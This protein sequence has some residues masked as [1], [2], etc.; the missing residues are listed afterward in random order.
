MTLTCAHADRLPLA[1]PPAQRVG[2]VEG[3]GG[4]E[5]HV[6][7]AVDVRERLQLVPAQGMRRGSR[8][9]CLLVVDASLVV[10]TSAAYSLAQPGI[11]SETLSESGVPFASHQYLQAR[12][13]PSLPSVIA[14]R[15]LVLVFQSLE[16]ADSSFPSH[17]VVR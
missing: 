5:A 3:Q 12:A 13:T 10:D 11:R 1:D 8:M 6:A 7:E 9:V 14:S 15:R 17:H 2:E 4:R 16:P